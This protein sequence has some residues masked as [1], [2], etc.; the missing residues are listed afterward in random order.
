MAS[1]TTEEVGAAETIA[2]FCSFR[3]PDDVRELTLALARIT[4]ELVDIDVDPEKKLG[5]GSAYEVYCQ[6]LKPRAT[7]AMLN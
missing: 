6:R 7:T 2:P 1:L 3:G 4:V 5:A